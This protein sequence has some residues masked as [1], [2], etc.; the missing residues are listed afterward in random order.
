MDITSDIYVLEQM[1]AQDGLTSDFDM[2]F[3]Q[4]QN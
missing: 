4:T 3:T 1:L 2:G